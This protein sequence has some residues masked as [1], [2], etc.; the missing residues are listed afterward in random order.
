MLTTFEKFFFGLAL[1][2]TMVLGIRA[3]F[4]LRNIIQRGSSDKSAPRLGYAIFNTITFAPVFRTRLPESVLHG[5]VA[6]GFIYFL[7][8]NLVDILEGLISGFSFLGSS[9]LGIVYRVFADISS[10]LIILAMLALLL[11]RFL[12]KP[13]EL[14]IRSD[15][16]LDERARHGIRRDSLIVGCF[17]ILHIGARLLGQGL[18][19]AEIGLDHWQPVASWIS[20]WF[21]AT[22]PAT[23]EIARHVSWWLALGSILMFIPYFPHSKHLHL[24][25]TPI[26]F[27]MKPTRRSPGALDPLDF[28]DES[29]EQFGAERIEQLSSS[30]ILDAYACIMCNRCQDVCPAYATGKSLSP[31]AIEINKRYFLKHEASL[32]AGGAD[33]HA[34]LTEY[35]LTPEAAWACTACGACLDICPVGNEPMLDIMEIRRQLVLMDNNFP[36]ALQTAFRGMERTQNPW[37]IP[38]DKR[39]DWAAGLD[40]PLA[41]DQEQVDLLWWVGCAPASDDRARKTARAFATLLQAAGVQFAVLGPEEACTG[42]AA[43]RAGNEYIFYE[44]ALQN[45]KTLNHVAPKQIVTTCPHCM[46]TLKHE[47]P[48]LGGNYEVIHHSELLQRLIGDGRL[49]L[50]QT[51]APTAVSYHDPCYLGRMSRIYEEPRNTLLEG[52]YALVELDRHHA[53]SFC[54][55][56]GGAQMWKEEEHGD[57]KVSANRLAEAVAGGAGTLAVACPFCLIMLEDERKTANAAIEIKDI[58][59]LLAEKLD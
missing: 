46:H 47:Y 51:A 13:A 24:I 48:A 38:A 55:G 56:A 17:I 29:I 23:L 7:L 37:N 1:L 50:K 25:M 57:E 27:A 33:S 22:A 28:E 49:Q 36:N 21:A 18:H 3:A 6:W 45:I 53:Q 12:L 30:S 15:I 40:I 26:N 14:T 43:R 11:R 44:L 8:V 54:C 31:A 9:W 39:M 19:L 16:L 42:D 32:L 34:A 58:A 59:E 41:A 10:A 4:Q 20:T 35:V 2:L 52:G 5:F